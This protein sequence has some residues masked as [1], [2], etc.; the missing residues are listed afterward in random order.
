MYSIFFLNAQSCLDELGPLHIKSWH[1]DGF[2]RTNFNPN[3]TPH[4]TDLK[5]VWNINNYS[6]A[7]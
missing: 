5:W 4:W 1:G 6:L 2:P 3:K 7:S